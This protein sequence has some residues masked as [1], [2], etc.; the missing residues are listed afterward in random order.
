VEQERAGS[1]LRPGMMGRLCGA[2][3]RSPSGAGFLEWSGGEASR[4]MLVAR[5]RRGW[6]WM[7][8]S[9][10]AG[11]GRNPTDGGAAGFS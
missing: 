9:C 7:D 1:H 6:L 4:E 3:H 8:G 5:R 2:E 10:F 11:E